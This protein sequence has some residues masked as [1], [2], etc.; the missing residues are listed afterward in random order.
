MGGQWWY[1][2]SDVLGVSL[3]LCQSVHVCVC[4][5]CVGVGG[6]VP[7]SS[8]YHVQVNHLSLD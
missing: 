7:I 2:S 8:E 5:A 4:D 3:E 1:S 6:W